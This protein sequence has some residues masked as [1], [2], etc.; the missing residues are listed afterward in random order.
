MFMT[1]SCAFYHSCFISTLSN[2]L[3]LVETLKNITVWPSRLPGDIFGAKVLSADVFLLLE[4]LEC[5][6]YTALWF[7]FPSYADPSWEFRS[8]EVITTPQDTRSHRTERK[9]ARFPATLSC[10]VSSHVESFVA[11]RWRRTSYHD[12]S[13][14]TIPW[15]AAAEVFGTSDEVAAT[16]GA[17]GPLGAVTVTLLW[18]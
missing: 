9:G 1:F 3:V 14:R 6:L 16:P 11:S 5:A 4:W 7:S 12:V 2:A 8:R 15:K 17:W 10:R 18:R 13:R